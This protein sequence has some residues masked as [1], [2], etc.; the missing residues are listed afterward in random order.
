MS[1]SFSSFKPIYSTADSA[2]FGNR[3]ALEAVVVAVAV[4]QNKHASVARKK[5]EEIGESGRINCVAIG[6]K[7]GLALY[8][9]R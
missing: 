1:S 9:R 5:R 7:V 6:R 8:P 2:T 4:L 3:L